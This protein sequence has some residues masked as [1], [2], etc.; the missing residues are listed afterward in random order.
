[1]YAGPIPLPE[2]DVLTSAAQQALE[3]YEQQVQAAGV[4]S[5]ERRLSDD[6]TEVTLLQQARYTDLVVLSQ[7]DPSDDASRLVSG[8][9][10]SII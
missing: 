8:L 1:M 5:Y 10:E 2:L 9:P 3:G 7:N 4:T 6:E